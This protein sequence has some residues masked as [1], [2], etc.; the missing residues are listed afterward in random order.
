VRRIPGE[1]VTRMLE[2]LEEE[3][4]WSLLSGRKKLEAIGLIDGETEKD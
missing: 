3:E 2:N 1:I 4:L